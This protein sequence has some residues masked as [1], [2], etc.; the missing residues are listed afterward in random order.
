MDTRTRAEKVKSL[1][2][3]FSDKE[4]GEVREALEGAE[5]KLISPKSSRGKGK[6]KSKLT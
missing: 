1:A 2:K 6:M 4:A 3:I 5:T